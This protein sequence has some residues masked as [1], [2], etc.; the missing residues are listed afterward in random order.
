MDEPQSYNRVCVFVCRE[1]PCKTDMDVLR[2]ID[3]SAVSPVQHPHVFQWRNSVL[4][5][6][7]QTRTQ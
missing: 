5:V 6:S 1:D 2:A 4:A 7:E 3:V